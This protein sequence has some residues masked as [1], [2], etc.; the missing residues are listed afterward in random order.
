MSE[1]MLMFKLGTIHKVRTLLRGE[2]GFII[3]VR[4]GGGKCAQSFENFNQI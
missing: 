2:G 1:V 3:S 4:W